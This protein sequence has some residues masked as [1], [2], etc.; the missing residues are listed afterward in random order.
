VPCSLVAVHGRAQLLRGGPVGTEWA[1]EAERFG[2][3]KKFGKLNI[4][5]SVTN[6]GKPFREQKFGI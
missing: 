3:V 4:L 5:K 1:T 6:R 2:Q